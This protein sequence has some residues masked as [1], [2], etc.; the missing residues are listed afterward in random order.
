MS[1]RTLR[2]SRKRK[3]GAEGPS[4]SVADEGGNQ[5]C[6]CC[7]LPIKGNEDRTKGIARIET[8]SHRFHFSCIRKWSQLETTCP[9]CKAVFTT[10]ERFC[11]K[12]GKVIEKV[13]C[14]SLFLWDHHDDDERHA[15]VTEEAPRQENTGSEGITLKLVLPDQIDKVKS[16]TKRKKPVKVTEAAK[17]TEKHL[18]RI[19]MNEVCYATP[20]VSYE[21]KPLSIQIKQKSEFKLKPVYQEDFIAK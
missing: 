1:A 18:K 13:K 3:A 5:S 15:N 19:A 9:Q 11:P 17:Y 20:S 10:I 4:D 16:P 21:A 12:S 8:C 2:S 6:D 14:E 7:L